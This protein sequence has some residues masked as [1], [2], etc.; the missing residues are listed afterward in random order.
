MKVNGSA[1]RLR[2]KVLSGMPRV[3]SILANSRQT[4]QMALGSIHMSTDLGM[5]DSGSTMSS[6]AKERRLGSME[7]NTSESTRTE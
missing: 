7:P 1:I 2:G 6:R 5:R 4:K 3:T